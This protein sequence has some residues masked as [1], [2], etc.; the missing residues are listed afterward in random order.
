MISEMQ[1]GLC[2]GRWLKAKPR[3]PQTA[4][5]ADHN[6]SRPHP[7]QIA[8]T[9]DRIPSRPQPQ[10]TT[11]FDRTSLEEFFY[12]LPPLESTKQ[13]VLREINYENE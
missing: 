1:Y 11:A 8:A 7:Q 3:R 5:P 4:V 9:A 13:I 12:L 10:Q 2:F 6:H